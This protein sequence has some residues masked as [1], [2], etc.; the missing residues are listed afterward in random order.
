MYWFTRSWLIMALITSSFPSAS[1]NCPIPSVDLNSIHKN[2]LVFPNRWRRREIQPP[3][4]HPPR[5]NLIDQGKLLKQLSSASN[6]SWTELFHHGT[7]LEN[8]SDEEVLCD[9]FLSWLGYLLS[10]IH[11]V[12]LESKVNRSSLVWGRVVSVITAISWKC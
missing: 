5:S 12:Q 7:G 1:K 11:Y 8:F 3:R 6:I 9:H 2:A 10:F 4:R